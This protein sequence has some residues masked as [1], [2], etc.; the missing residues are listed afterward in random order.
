[1]NPIGKLYYFYN[2]K[3]LINN[4]ESKDFDVIPRNQYKSKFYS[5]IFE[6]MVSNERTRAVL[7]NFTSGKKSQPISCSDK[8]SQKENNTFA[9]EH[10][11]DENE[12]QMIN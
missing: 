6:Q 3:E 8:K 10:I 12:L 7:N 4:K 1:M 11:F 2:K 5:K 9:A